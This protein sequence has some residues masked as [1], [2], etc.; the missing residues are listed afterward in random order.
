MPEHKTEQ[1][2]LDAEV[3]LLAAVTKLVDHL[4]E[5]VDLGKRAVEEGLVRET[6]RF[7][8]RS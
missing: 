2:K 1:H 6:A 5:L 4:T 7:R 3:A 8:T